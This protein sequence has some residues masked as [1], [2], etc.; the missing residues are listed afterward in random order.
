M[1]TTVTGDRSV[2]SKRRS[3]PVAVKVR[4]AAGPASDGE[5]QTLSLSRCL[6]KVGGIRTRTN[7]YS[8]NRPRSR[9]GREVPFQPARRISA[10]R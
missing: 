2:V 1:M 5:D 4:L 9:A 3:K 6:P 7:A 8:E 10:H